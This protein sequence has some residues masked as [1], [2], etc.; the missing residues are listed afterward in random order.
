[1]G[2]IYFTRLRHINDLPIL[3]EETYIGNKNLPRFTVRNLEKNSL[4][5]TLRKN[6]QVEIKEG[7]Q[8]I[9]AI[10][11]DAEK[12]ELLKTQIGKPLLHMKRKLITNV[13]DL[14]IYSFLYCNTQDYFIQDYF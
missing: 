1:M 13:P 10:E 2:C 5:D 7:E 6:Y 14:H 12:V 11:A 8:K 9:W 4:F 3:Y